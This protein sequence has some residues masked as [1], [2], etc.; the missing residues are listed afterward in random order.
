MQYRRMPIEVESPEQLGYD[1]IKYNLSESSVSDL[2]LKDLGKL[3]DNILLCF[4]RFA[5][6]NCKRRRNKKY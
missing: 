2:F 4:G 1:T 3:D 5:K 6:K